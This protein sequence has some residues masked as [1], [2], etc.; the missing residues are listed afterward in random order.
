[1]T[2]TSLSRLL[3]KAVPLLALM[4]LPQSAWAAPDES[5]FFNDEGYRK[6]QYRAPTPDTAPGATTVTTEELKARMDNG[7][8]LGLIDV[9]PTP[10]RP[11]DL[12]ANTLWAP[13]RHGNI[14]GSLWLPDAG[15]P[16]LSP[17]LESYFKQGLNKAIDNDKSVPVVIY[18]RENCWMS[19]NAAKRASLWG[20]KVLWY[21]GGIEQW[22]GAGYPLVDASPEPSKEL[23]R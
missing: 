18:C 16:V 11:V 17:A 3:I 8:R 10:P 21:Q 15:Q 22:T 6:D 1:M 9:L 2:M 23:G 20:Y 4:V 13:A 12:P 19:W 14:A 7:D 5:A